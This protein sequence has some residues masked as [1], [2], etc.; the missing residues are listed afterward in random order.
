M[1]GESAYTTSKERMVP[2]LM[3]SFE[4]TSQVS[5]TEKVI[6]TSLSAV[7][8]LHSVTKEHYEKHLC[9]PVTVEVSV[10]NVGKPPCTSYHKSTLTLLCHV[11]ITI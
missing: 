5:I 10:T 11:S 8:Q 7:S 9:N 6:C 4:Q 1:T 3:F 2:Y